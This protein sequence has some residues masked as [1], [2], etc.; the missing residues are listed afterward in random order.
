MKVNVL[1]EKLETAIE[2]DMAKADVVVRFGKLRGG[3]GLP[4]EIVG[5]DSIAGE[6]ILE[7][8]EL[9][10]ANYPFLLE[11]DVCGD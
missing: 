7:V 8:P 1:K 6:L 5:Y 10:K 2:F 9:K 11:D 3:K 4:I